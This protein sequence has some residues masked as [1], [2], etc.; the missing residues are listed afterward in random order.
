MIGTRASMRQRVLA[1]LSAVALAGLIA[2]ALVI[3]NADRHL[4]ENVIPEHQ[5]LREVEQESTVL[6]QHYY[7]YMFLPDS[8]EHSEIEQ[9]QASLRDK[10][11]KYRKL[12]ASNES[13]QSYLPSIE[14]AVDDLERSGV[15]M[16]SLRLE[17][18]RLFEQGEILEDEV[19]I[20][21][22]LYRGLSNQALLNDLEARRWD[23]LIDHSLPDVRMIAGIEQLVL[24]LFLQIRDYQ[25]YRQPGA[26]KDIDEIESRLNVSF[27]MLRTYIDAG[28][29]RAVE[30]RGIVAVY[31]KLSSLIN[32]YMHASHAA[33]DSVSAVEQAGAA[34]S[35]ALER[36]G[37]Q[38]ES[39]GW[40]ALRQSLLTLGAILVVALLGSFLVLYF[41]IGRILKPMQ[42][43]Q[44]AFGDIG[45]GN[46]HLHKEIELQSDDAEVSKLV[47]AFN[48]MAAQLRQNAVM[49]QSF[50]EHLEEKN[51]EL[52]RFTYTVSH[53]LKSPLVT[54]SGFLGLL[55]KDLSR[56]RMARVDE[57]MDKIGAAIR[58]L[59]RQLED[60][61]DLSRVGRASNPAECF[62]LTALCTESVQILQGLIEFSDAE[63]I[64]LPDMPEVFA[65]R[66]R[67]G[68]AITNLVENGIKFSSRDR[69]AR[70]EI[71]AET[72]E[73][74]VLC[75]VQDNGP[76]IEP[77][78]RERVFELFDRL[79]TDVPGTGIGLALVKRIVEI[80]GGTIWI[81]AA[82][83]GQGCC[84]CF[85]LPAPGGS[86]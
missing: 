56:G 84:F 73:N 34:L 62:S 74:R 37:K 55:K 61:L 20:V 27:T 29:E 66:V 26:L 83:N 13:M 71:S 53:E 60:L 50:I 32:Q 40:E 64:F 11:T 9:T 67:V 77:E 44:T 52:E 69:R 51:T 72:H 59:N 31:E 17:L 21:F 18:E 3:Y 58:V 35:R 49:Q 41:G 7:N 48:E 24:E 86:E 1:L 10:L 57:D 30:A 8:V 42:Q 63:I 45:E 5:A 16:I 39:A 43:L 79:D 85:T 23:N 81:D 38:T 6:V 22:E 75:R 47:D 28:G 46:L 36:T 70:V 14:S 12:V 33:I 4:F 82:E 19:R 80:H 15:R 78:Y 65:D 76:G 54:V 2:L 25:S 68:E